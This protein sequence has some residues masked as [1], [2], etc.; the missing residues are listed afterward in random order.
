LKESII[1]VYFVIY[2]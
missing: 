1:G 2:T